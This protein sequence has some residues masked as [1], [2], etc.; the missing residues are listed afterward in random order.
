MN[1]VHK[2]LSQDPVA[3]V[4]MLMDIT[5][6]LY[7]VM[8]SEASAI[9]MRDEVRMLDISTRKDVLLLQ[10]QV[11]VKEFKSRVEEFRGVDRVLLDRLEDQQN[12]L[13]QI[14]N[15]NQQWLAVQ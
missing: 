6:E 5:R 2:I 1:T 4:E 13:S 3:A 15:D 10:Y 14:T 8:E 7:E 11:A 12:L 9:A